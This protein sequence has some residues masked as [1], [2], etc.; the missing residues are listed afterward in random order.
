ML[1]FQISNPV[2]LEGRERL[3]EVVKRARGDMSQRK[4][5]EILGVKHTTVQLWE[6]G[7]T[8]PEVDN[9]TQIAVRAGYTLE[10]LLEYLE[11]RPVERPSD[12]S[13]ILKQINKLPI[14][15]VALIVQAGCERLISTAK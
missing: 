15:D 1:S 4:F 13:Q 12:V 10:G 2:N 5:G 7:E 3:I 11:G 9:L 6:R 14:Q 8:M